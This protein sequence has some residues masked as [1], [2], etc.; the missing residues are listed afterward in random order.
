MTI[1]LIAMWLGIASTLAT[2]YNVYLLLVINLKIA[3]LKLDILDASQR[4]QAEVLSQVSKTYAA[5]AV[6]RAQF[7]DLTHR[8]DAISAGR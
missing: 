4:Q 8:I 1:Q 7:E 6:V 2:A 3:Q 5:E